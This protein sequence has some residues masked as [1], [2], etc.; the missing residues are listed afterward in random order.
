MNDTNYINNGA[1][2]IHFMT[3]FMKKLFLFLSDMTVIIQAITTTL[4]NPENVNID[5]RIILQSTIQKFGHEGGRFSTDFDDF[6]G[7]EKGDWTVSNDTKII[8]LR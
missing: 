5:C 2:Q 1:I 4:K 8:K 3:I 6:G 7:V